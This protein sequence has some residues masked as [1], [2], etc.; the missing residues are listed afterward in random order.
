M[1][2]ISWNAIGWLPLRMK[3]SSKYESIP[4]LTRGSSSSSSSSNTESIP[5]ESASTTSLLSTSTAAAAASTTN[6]MLVEHS[7]DRHL[8][9]VWRA[10][11]MGIALVGNVIRE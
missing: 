5:S 4:P 3:T 7:R 8:C 2:A 6:E 10:R 9:D 1:P 11:S